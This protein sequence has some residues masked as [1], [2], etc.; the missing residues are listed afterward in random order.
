MIYDQKTSLLL[1]YYSMKTNI[2]F[3]FITKINTFPLLIEAKGKIVIFL[4][5]FTITLLFLVAITYNRRIKEENN[6]GR[7]KGT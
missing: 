4:V 1:R 3:H 5:N 6:V 7:N 2:Y